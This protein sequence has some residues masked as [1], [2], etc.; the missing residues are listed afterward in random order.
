MFTNDHF[1][2]QVDDNRKVAVQRL[3]YACDFR[4]WRRSKRSLFL[5]IVWLVAKIEPEIGS[6]HNLMVAYTQETLVSCVMQKR[7]VSARSACAVRKL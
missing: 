2:D 3:V 1:R 5:A 4:F 6:I 7:Y